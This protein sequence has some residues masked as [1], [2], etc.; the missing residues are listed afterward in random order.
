M[1]KPIFAASTK[2]IQALADGELQTIENLER[3]LAGRV[4]MYIDY[5]NVRPWSTHLK[6]NIDTLRLKQFLR[7]FSCIDEIK[8]YQGTLEEDPKSHEE[9]AKLKNAGYIVRTKPVKIM[10]H[11]IDASSIASTSDVLL[12]Q[13]IR[14]ALLREYRGSVIEYLNMEFIQMNQAG[15]LFITDRKCNFDVEI[16]VDMLLDMERDKADTFVLWSGDSDFSDPV[17]T[18]LDAG[19]KVI[20]FGTARKISRELGALRKNGLIIF[21]IKKIRQFICWK[22]EI[23]PMKSKGDL[24]AK[25][26]KH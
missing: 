7:S 25:A 4:F 19:K 20:L 26:P 5:A 16:G 24:F 21:D 17:K 2:K 23:L 8:F 9:I 11:S 6:W 18:L 14:R 10:K 1:L 15:T 22:R 13:F 12:S 3:L